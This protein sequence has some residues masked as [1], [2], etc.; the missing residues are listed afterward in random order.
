MNKAFFYGLFFFIVG[1]TLAWY[2]TNLQFVSEW[3]KE[4][5][6]LL[7]AIL[8]LPTGLAYIY[9][10]KFMMSWHPELWTSRFIAFSISYISF[11]LLT[12]Y[13]L[14]ESP[15]TLKTIL[16]SLLAFTIVMVQIGMK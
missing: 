11:P 5:P 14:G 10:A 9:G 16:C 6:I 13:H 1:H 8:S 2:S 12:W 3:W 4:R 15:F 7:C